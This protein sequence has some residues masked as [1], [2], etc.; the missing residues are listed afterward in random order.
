LSLREI[1]FSKP[2]IGDD[3]IKAV[4]DVLRSGWITTGEKTREF[5]E[6]FSRYIGSRYAVA[7]NSG[8]A[9]LHLS[10]EVLGIKEGDE[11][12]LPTNTFTATAEACLYCNAHPKFV[13]IDERTFNINIDLLEDGITEKTKGI[14]AVHIGGYP[15]DMERIE[16][17]GRRYEVHVIEDAAHAI[18]A[19]Y[20]GKKIGDISELTAFSFYSTKNITTGEGGMIT[21]NNGDFAERL[22]ILRLHGMSKDAWKRYRKGGNWYYEIEERGYKYNPSDILAALGIQQLKKIKKF[23]NERRTIFEK[24]NA[25]LEEVDELIVPE[26]YDDIVHAHHLYIIR[27]KTGELNINRDEFIE[28]LKTLGIECSV[29]FIPL[30]LQPFYQ[31]RFGYKAGDFPIAERIYREVVSLPIYPELKLEDVDYIV[32][33]IKRVVHENRRKIVG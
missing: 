15:C 25:Y 17:I 8:T 31:G 14:I 3:D 7:V 26:I 29:H 28:E 27:L 11:V 32:A 10:L 9:A 2:S 16:Q 21:T 4:V 20:K 19:K 30:H 12:I 5:E 18:E 24:Y 22:K 13:D 1:D 6:A 23:H 33:A